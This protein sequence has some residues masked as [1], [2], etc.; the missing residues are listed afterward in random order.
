[1]PRGRLREGASIRQ[2]RRQAFLAARRMVSVD[3][4]AERV[5]RQVFCE[6]HPER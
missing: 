4:V 5:E 6:R 1:V 2:E 3:E